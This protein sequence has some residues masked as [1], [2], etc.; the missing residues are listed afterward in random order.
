[1]RIVRNVRGLTLW[2][3]G[4]RTPAAGYASERIMGRHSED[5]TMMKL[6]GLWKK[7]ESQHFFRMFR[8]TNKFS[9]Y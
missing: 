1:M 5:K 4:L 9:T 3:I 8:V 7:I 2:N 6:T